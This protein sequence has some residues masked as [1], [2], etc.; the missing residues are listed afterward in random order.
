M[1]PSLRSRFQRTFPAFGHRN[2]RLFWTGQCVSLVGTWMQNIG[3][4]TAL[5]TGSTLGALSLAAR[6]K[7]GPKLP[8]LLLGALGMSVFSLMVGLQHGFFLSCALL[9]LT[10]FC[11]IICTAQIN[12]T[13]QIHS[14][15]DMRGRVTSVYNLSFGGVTP[16]GSLYAGSLVNGAG[17]AAALVVS[18]AM[19]ILS[20]GVCA[21]ALFG[22]R[23]ERITLNH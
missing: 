7:D 8:I 17:A 18:G 22:K 4:L 21:F 15:D 1:N 3:Q 13:L 10:G 23:R 2:F 20:T 9:A 16:I 6:S 11:Q 14:S 12:A 19:G 5:G